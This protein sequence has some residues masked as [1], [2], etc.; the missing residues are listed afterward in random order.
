[1]EGHQNGHE[2]RVTAC[3]D[4]ER[5]R[6]VLLGDDVPLGPHKW[7]GYPQGPPTVIPK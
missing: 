2:A 4:A 5:I 6:L 7:E 1:M 3:S